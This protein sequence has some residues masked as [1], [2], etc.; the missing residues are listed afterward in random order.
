MANA[1][2]CLSM[3]SVYWGVQRLGR[4]GPYVIIPSL[5]VGVSLWQPHQLWSLCGTIQWPIYSLRGKSG[6]C[7]RNKLI[8]TSPH[9]HLA[10]MTH[11]KWLKKKYDDIRVCSKCWESLGHHGD[12]A[13]MQAM[14]A[15]TQDAILAQS[16]AH[17]HPLHP[18][19]GNK[20]QKPQN[21]THQFSR[22]LPLG[23]PLDC[24]INLLLLWF[25]QI[26]CVQR[27]EGTE[28]VRP[29][30]SNCFKINCILINI[31]PYAYT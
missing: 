15:T 2:F 26:V 31:Y 10:R 3:Q 5:C 8:H 21:K 4:F 1:R 6:P 28:R 29:H 25:R 30:N 11:F 20:K 18:S 16:Q 22:R 14:W 12:S 27:G 13:A 24:N 19:K 17:G 7:N 9:P 23:C